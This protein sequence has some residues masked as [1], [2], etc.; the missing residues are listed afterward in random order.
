ME[1][2]LSCLRC[3]QDMVFLRRE[4]LQL[5]KTGLFTGDWGN[6]L[7]GALDVA[8][9]QCTGCGKLEFFK[10]DAFEEQ[11]EGPA[12]D[13]AQVTCPNCG[14]RYATIPSARCAAQRTP[15]FKEGTRPWAF[16]TN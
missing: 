11:D 13:L 10:G 8:I 16:L 14:V 3:G 5:G 2:K 1:K 15:F 6:L 9:L 7:A 12:G 4:H